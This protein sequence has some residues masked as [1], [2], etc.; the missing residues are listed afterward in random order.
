MPNNVVKSIARRT[1]KSPAEVEGKWQQAKRL[2]SHEYPH[3]GEKDED[4]WAIVNSLTHKLSGVKESVDN[5]KTL[6]QIHANAFSM[7]HEDGK[8]YYDHIDGFKTDADGAGAEVIDHGDGTHTAHFNGE[9]IGKFHHTPVSG[10]D[11]GYGHME[12]GAGLVNSE[13]DGGAEGMIGE[14]KGEHPI[15][16]GA[17]IGAGTGALVGSLAGPAGAIVGGTTGAA[18]GATTGAAVGAVRGT[19]RLIGKGAKAAYKAATDKKKE[20]TKEGVAPEAGSSTAAPGVST[21]GASE[22]PHAAT[23]TGVEDRPRT[24]GGQAPNGLEQ[25][26]GD[27][28]VLDM[29]PNDDEKRDED[30][31]MH[32]ESLNFEQL[33]TEELA[34]VGDRTVVMKP[35]EHD[36]Y[37]SLISNLTGAD[38]EHIVTAW[39]EIC[40]AAAAES[41]DLNPNSDEFHALVAMDVLDMFDDLNGETEEL[42]EAKGEHPIV[43][44]AVIGAGT[45]ALVGSVGG[46]VGAAAGAGAGAVVGAATGAAVGAV[47]GTA[48]LAEKG[49]KRV[50][51]AHADHEKAKKASAAEHQQPKAQKEAFAPAAVTSSPTGDKAGALVRGPDV[52]VTNN[53]PADR[54][55]NAV[56]APN[57]VGSEKNASFNGGGNGNA[58]GVNVEPAKVEYKDGQLVLS[59]V[60]VSSGTSVDGPGG[61]AVLGPAVVGPRLVGQTPV[62]GEFGAGHASTTANGTTK[63]TNISPDGKVYREN[64]EVPLVAGEEDEEGT[65]HAPI[66]DDGTTKGTN[67]T[68]DAEVYKETVLGTLAGGAVGAVAGG[69]VGH[70]VAGA[71]IG[72]A[73]GQH[74]S[75]KTD[76]ED[77]HKV[78][79]GEAIEVDD[80]DE[81]EVENEEELEREEKE[82]KKLGLKEAVS[83]QERSRIVALHTAIKRLAALRVR[84][85]ELLHAK[86]STNGVDAEINAEKNRINHLRH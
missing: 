74:L 86:V 12:L 54:G 70:G 63:G 5:E 19:A 62:D 8:A 81:E 24:P 60:V 15:L 71:L 69:A 28:P 14:A 59:P 67:A 65:G 26:E 9:E 85:K 33:V 50:E 16:K 75:N 25:E 4:F 78:A 61:A 20:V 44:G 22:A 48:R 56:E 21:G 84:K 41:P 3:L 34:A 35:F 79:E 23:S 72:G 40:K 46:H 2:T 27:D 38:K 73:V 68:D 47:R 29:P 83:R 52:A 57:A 39:N 53:G 77:E 55:T 42:H 45:G 31:G 1:G 43:K 66:H 17:A 37:I 82:A 6:K 32:L 7:N 30:V 18:V 58:P 80:S 51:K 64:E 49:I 11:N 13:P 36:D 10:M 76:D